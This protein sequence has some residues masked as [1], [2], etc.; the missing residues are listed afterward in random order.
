MFSIG[1]LC[2]L[3][4]AFFWGNSGVLLKSLP[5]KIR[6]SFIYFESIISGTILII[7]ITI[8]GQWDGFKEFSHAKAVYKQTKFNLMKLAGLV[9]P[10]KKKEQKTNTA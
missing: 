7:L 1:E 8:F 10:Y 3:L 6:A 5:S 2:A 9:P 4:S